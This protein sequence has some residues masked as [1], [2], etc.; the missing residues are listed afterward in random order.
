MIIILDQSADTKIAKIPRKAMPGATDSFVTECAESHNRLYCPTGTENFCETAKGCGCAQKNLE[1][2][3]I[4]G[5]L[6]VTGVNSVV[7]TARRKKQT[8]NLVPVS[9]CV[10][11][12]PIVSPLSQLPTIF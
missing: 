5:N 9:V 6:A 4:L 2:H 11:H 12:V 1:H 3:R 7:K 10:S 8:D